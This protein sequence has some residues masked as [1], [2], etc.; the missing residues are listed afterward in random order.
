MTLLDFTGL[1]Y[2]GYRRARAGHAT[3]AA[4]P[5]NRPARPSTD[6]EL[7]LLIHSPASS[8]PNIPWV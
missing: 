4:Y 7:Y 3:L 2:A 5:A 8:R 6:E 1:G